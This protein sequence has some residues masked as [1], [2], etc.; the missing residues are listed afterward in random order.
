MPANKLKQLLGKG[1]M[2]SDTLR[3]TITHC[4]GWYAAEPSLATFALLSL[5]RDLERRGWDDKQGVP[6]AKY[7]PFKNMV[8]PHLLRIADILSAAPSAEPIDELDE[9]AVA[10]RDPIR[11]TP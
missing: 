11:A 3:D 10:Y 7:D 5:F 2:V 1:P 9:L 4:D 6:A 8:L